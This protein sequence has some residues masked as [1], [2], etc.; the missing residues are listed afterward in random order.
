VPKTHPPKTYPK[1]RLVSWD[2]EL[3]RVRTRKLAAL[4][5]KVEARPLRECGGVVGHFRDVAPDA[6]V[7]DLDR[8]PSQGRAVATMLRDSKSTRHLPLVFAG[9]AADKVERIRGELPDAVFTAW[10]RVGD[11]VREAIAHPVA[12]PVKAKSH[13]A[14]FAGTPL[15]QK[16]GIKAGMQA[17]VLGGFEGFEEILGELPE[18]AAVVKNFIAE[19]RL[20][21]YI[22]RTERELGDA[23]EHASGRLADG[24]SFWV[25]YPKQRKNAQ[26]EFNENDVRELGLAS[27]FVDFTI[28]SVNAEWSGLKFARRKK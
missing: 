17:A 2:D 1:I 25:I 21:L 22:V 27:G 19:T 24:A 20:G 5:F 8:L 7:L 4:G 15:V 9:G 11:A 23:L 10:E 13:A 3:A 6:V 18:G 16:L 14:R 28:C 26:R 12:N